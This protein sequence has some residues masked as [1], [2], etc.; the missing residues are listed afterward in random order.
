MFTLAIVARLQPGPA[1]DRIR[2]GGNPSREHPR[3]F[4]VLCTRPFDFL[5]RRALGSGADS[6]AD[7]IFR[8]RSDPCSPA[9]GRRHDAISYAGL[10]SRRRGSVAVQYGGVVAAAG[11][12][13]PAEVC[14]HGRP[15]TLGPQDPP[16]GK[17]KPDTT[18][19]GSCLGSGL[20][21]RSR[22][23][24]FGEAQTRRRY[25]FRCRQRGTCSPSSAVR[26]HREFT[27]EEKNFGRFRRLRIP[28][29]PLS[30]IPL[31]SSLQSTGSFWRSSKRRA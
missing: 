5:D 14:C 3:C 11:P 4:A 6:G 9:I 27:P 29:F 8:R 10:M 17:P 20:A 28:P 18:G 22:R 12:G 23:R 13:A 7:G 30:K 16:S 21:P 19:K 15:G 25:R 24:H 31:G 2:A 26:K 1:V